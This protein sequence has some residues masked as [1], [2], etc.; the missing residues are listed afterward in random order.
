MNLLERRQPPPQ[1]PRAPQPLR[2]RKRFPNQI[3][4]GQRTR[5]NLKAARLSRWFAH[6]QIAYQRELFQQPIGC[7]DT[8]EFWGAELSGRA[9]KIGRA[10]RRGHLK[11]CLRWKLRYFFVSAGTL[12][13]FRLLLIPKILASLFGRRAETLMR[14]L[15]SKVMNPLSNALSRFG[16]SNRPLLPSSRSLFDD[17]FHGLM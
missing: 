5:Q 1:P 9:K 12:L 11:T 6:W 3:R 4:M 2:R 7:R 10:G 13:N 8:L 14:P 15:S 16:T 17:F